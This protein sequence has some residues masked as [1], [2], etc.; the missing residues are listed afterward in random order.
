MTHPPW[1]PFV[2][3]MIKRKG[4]Q[5]GFC[6]SSLLKACY[7]V[8]RRADRHKCN[9]KGSC[10]QATKPTTT[11]CSEAPAPGQGVR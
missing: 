6:Y 8:G 2:P 3:R 1:K 9:E 10:L 5:R 7:F 11:L 4:C